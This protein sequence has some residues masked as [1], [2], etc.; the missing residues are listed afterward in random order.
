MPR[1]ETQPSEGRAQPLV[2]SPESSALKARPVLPPDVPQHFIPIRGVRPSGATLLY[3]P[4]VL[5]SA[6]VRFAD[7]KKTI[8]VTQNVQA[9]AP[10]VREALPVDWDRATEVSLT[11]SDLERT[12]GEDS[13]FVELPSAAGKAK[14]Y[15]LWSKDFAGWLFRNQKVELFTSPGLKEISK[16]GE[17]ERDFRV[18]LQLKARERRDEAAEDLRRK[19]AP[20][21]AALQE[22]K[23]RAEQAVEREAG[24]AKQSQI[25]AAISVG[26][27]LLG[28][29]MGRKAISTSTIGKA[30]TA[31]RG[32]GRAMKDSKDVGL[33]KDTV[34]AIDQQINELETQFKSN[35]EALAA[36]GDPL[37]ETLETVAL[38]PNKTNIAVKLV[39][40]AWTPHWQD[41]KGNLTPAWM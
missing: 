6:Q 41:G 33:A 20:K 23:R 29:F 40:L 30:T 7:P 27:T 14:S 17:S 37:T 9:L 32:A 25:Q 24:Q 16:L 11:V 31:I 4:M 34:A 28:A 12:P 10:I 15:E 22:R 2:L 8:D 1:T 39:A 13:R 19:F 36:A 18:R 5:G 38:K 21:L 26:A 3:Q 35:V